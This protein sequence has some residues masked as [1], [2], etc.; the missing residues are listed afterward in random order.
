MDWQYDAPLD[1]EMDF[2]WW[3]RLFVSCRWALPGVF[4]ADRSMWFIA[5]HLLNQEFIFGATS[6]W[7]ATSIFSIASLTSEGDDRS[8]HRARLDHVVGARHDS[9]DNI[10]RRRYGGGGSSTTAWRRL[11]R[12]DVA[13]YGTATAADRRRLGDGT[14]VRRR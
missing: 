5:V 2:I 1:E 6:P 4:D 13:V 9:T 10:A 3:T 11:E 14:A 7:R 12:E 8:G